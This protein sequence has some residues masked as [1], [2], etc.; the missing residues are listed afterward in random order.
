M[1]LY[2]AHAALESSRLRA[3]GIFRMRLIEFGDSKL[4]CREIGGS[5]GEKEKDGARRDGSTS[6]LGRNWRISAALGWDRG[7]SATEGWN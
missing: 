3:I 5:R 2:V 1:T 7:S 6:R 4:G